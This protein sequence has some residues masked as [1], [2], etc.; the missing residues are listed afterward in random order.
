[1]TIQLTTIQT[2]IS[3]T[4]GG[5]GVLFAMTKEFHDQRLKDRKGW[6]CPNGCTRTFTRST[7]EE[8]LRRR[9]EQAEARITFER[10][11]A[12]AAHRSAAAYKGVATKLRNRIAAGQCPCC[13]QTFPDLAEHIAGE[14]PDYAE[15]ATK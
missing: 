12:Q 7:E 1:M 15:T 4:C 10:D 5:C 9:A 14:H 3:H 6:H 11:Q 13:D 2:F 8:R